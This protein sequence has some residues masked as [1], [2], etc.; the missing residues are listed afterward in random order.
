M[1][2][3]GR[4]QRAGFGSNG[5][6]P[7]LPSVPVFSGAPSGGIT[8]AQPEGGGPALALRPQ[9]LYTSRVSWF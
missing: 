4:L 6:L 5:A 8:G 3:R 1:G 7:A 9:Q 2:V